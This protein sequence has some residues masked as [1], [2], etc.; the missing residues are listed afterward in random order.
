MNSSLF[1]IIT[2]LIFLVGNK[3]VERISKRNFH[4]VLLV[5]TSTNATSIPFYKIK[6][7]VSFSLLYRPYEIKDDACTICCT[8]S[9]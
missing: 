3:I 9:N 8:L 5:Q 1:H 6:V 4:N 2:I 7:R